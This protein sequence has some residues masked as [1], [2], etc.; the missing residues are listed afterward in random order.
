MAIKLIAVDMD[1]TFL[2]SKMEYDR[3]WFLRLYEQMEAKGIKFVVASGNQYAQLRSYFP[4]MKDEIAFVSENGALIA[5]AN[6]VV[7]CAELEKSNVHQVLDLL[8]SINPR[9]YVMCGLE[10]AYVHTDIQDKSY[11][12]VKLYYHKLKK[13]DD[14]YNV[15][16][17]IFKFCTDF[18][19]FELVEMMERVSVELDGIMVPVSTGHGGVDFIIPGI[20]KAN[21]IKMLQERWQIKDDEI[22]AFGDSG[23]DLEMLRHAKYSY[24]MAN[25][26][27]DVKAAAKYE[28]E[29]NDENGVLR[30]IE[31]ILTDI[32]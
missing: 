16:D 11:E 13:V 30:Q 8:E 15:D 21:G 19:M 29:S 17:V 27:P 22:A 4:Q 18:S 3:E 6:E 12:F 2:N 14:L 10:S 24:A 20:H 5:D 28:I 7:F 26:H 1:G 31:R 23:N 25:A 32:E 9:E